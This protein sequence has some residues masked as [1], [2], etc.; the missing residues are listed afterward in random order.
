MAENSL[1]G[2][3]I[4]KFL[5]LRGWKVLDWDKNIPVSEQTLCPA[6]DEKLRTIATLVGYEGRQKLRVGCCASCGYIGYIDRPTK[7]W[8]S[9]F[10]FEDWAGAKERDIGEHVAKLKSSPTDKARRGVTMLAEKYDIDKNRYVCEI[11]VGH[12]ETL[13]KFGKM[14]FK[15]LIG[16]ESSKYRA[17]VASKA[18]GLKVLA[19]DFEE[20]SAQAELKKLAPFSLIFSYHVMEHVYDPAEI[21]KLASDLQ[22]E[23]DY[24]IVALPNREG[25]LSMIT[26]DYFPHLHSYTK[27]FL[28][29]LLAKYNYE[30]IDDTFTTSRNLNLIAKKISEVQ[31]RYKSV[32]AKNYFDKYVAKFASALGMDKK[33]FWPRRRMWWFRKVDIGGQIPFYGNNI[34]GSIHW[35]LRKRTLPRLNRQRIFSEVGKNKY[36]IKN[37]TQSALVTDIEK[38]YTDAPIEIQFEGPIKLLYK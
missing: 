35:S 25:E 19:A 6:D 8:I 5:D 29:R 36:I 10:Y 34:L 12:G 32:D 33:Y 1:I 27:E 20:P 28:T 11:G 23:G 2:V 4:L 26:L 9:K 3:K 17:E 38:K 31:P 14:G 16:L 24:M 18:F 30:V 22:K 15:K 13:G 7:E 37:I 21:V